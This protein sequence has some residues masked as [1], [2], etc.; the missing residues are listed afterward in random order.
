[1]TGQLGLFEG[2]KLDEPE[3]TTTLRVGRRTVQ[4]PLRRKRREAIKRLTEILEELEGK[5]IHIGS[6][7]AGGRHFWS[8]T[9]ALRLPTRTVV[10]GSGSASFV[11]SNKSSCPVIFLLSFGI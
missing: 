5:D 1:M 8:G 4:I 9:W 10:V 2:V 7:D 3:P 6:Y 11:P